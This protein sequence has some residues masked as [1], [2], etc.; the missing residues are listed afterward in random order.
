MKIHICYRNI[1]VSRAKTQDLI[2]SWTKLSNCLKILKK[3]PENL[4]IFLP[5]VIRFE[6]PHL[7]NV[8]QV[9]QHFGTKS[10]IIMILAIWIHRWYLSS[11]CFLCQNYSFCVI[12]ANF[13]WTFL[14]FFAKK[15]IF[16]NFFVPNRSFFGPNW[17][18]RWSQMSSTIGAGDS[19]QWRRIDT[20][21]RP[22][23]LRIHHE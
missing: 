12:F 5:K 20:I 18:P 1:I 15:L 7:E 8:F 17:C 22:K 10:T 2:F 16:W 6:I 11:R 19:G 3:V 9:S 13:L 4:S 21:L 14:N 23:W